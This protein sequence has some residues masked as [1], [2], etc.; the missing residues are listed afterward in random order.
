MRKI[1]YIVVSSALLV[2]VAAACGDDPA[3]TPPATLDDGGGS[4]GSSTADASTSDG[5]GGADAS[6]ASD[7]DGHVEAS[8][9]SGPD[10]DADAG[11]QPTALLVG[12]T[13][14]T[15]QGWTVLM[16]APATVTNGAD[17]VRLETTTNMGATTSG[18]LLI[19]HPAAVVP[20]T[21]FKISVVMLVESVNAH[22]QLDSAAAILGSFAGGFGTATERAEMIYLDSAAIGWADDT[23]SAAVA[24]TNG[25]Y[26]TYELD[27]DAAGVAHVSVDGVA[28]LTRTGFVTNGTIAIGD[29][30]NDPNVDGV[31]RIKSVTKLCP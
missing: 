17:Y 1:R 18:Q 21:P 24:V 12:G 26:H 7:P 19:Q 30:T 14:I 20:G 9:D 10:A 28:A 16:Q 15:T 8:V 23:Q 25:A 11:C 31:V 5:S 6:D 4:D 13:D 3:D 22:N 2:A 27:V 29:Q